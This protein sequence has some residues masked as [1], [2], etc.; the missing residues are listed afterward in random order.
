MVNPAQL[1]Q[2]VLLS[3][4]ANLARHILTLITVQEL[5]FRGSLTMTKLLDLLLVSIQKSN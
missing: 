1:I 2:Q 3:S 4:M 5:T